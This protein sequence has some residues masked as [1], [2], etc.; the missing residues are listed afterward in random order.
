MPVNTPCDEYTNWQERWKLVRTVVE[1]ES[2]IKKSGEWALPRPSGQ[3][4][5]DYKE[6]LERA[7][8]FDVVSRT[9]DSFHGLIFNK[10]PTQTGKINEELLKNVDGAGKTLRKFA[11][12]VIYDVLQTYWGGILVDFPQVFPEQTQADAPRNAYLK[13]YTAESVINWQRGVQKGKLGTTLVVLRENEEK[14]I[15]DD[16]FVIEKAESYRVLMLDENGNYIQRKY[17]KDEKGGF[18]ECVII[19]PR[20]NNKTLDFI[21]FR[22]CPFD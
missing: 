8:F 15:N 5:N 17:I 16:I 7:R 19:E 11:D 13:W 4:D 6:Y 21:P 10:E 3:S 1:G 18:S 2:A 14:R 9:C 12:D 20:L 22:F